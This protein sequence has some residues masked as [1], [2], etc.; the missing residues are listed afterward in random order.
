MK[1]FICAFGN[2]FLGIPAEQIQ[3]VIPVVRVQGSVFDTDDEE[4][5]ISIP[6]LFR[7]KGAAFNRET[8]HGL[9]LKDSLRINNWPGKIVLLVPK[10]DIDLEIPEEKIQRLPEVFAGAFVFFSGVC[11]P[12]DSGKM[13]LILD[14]EKLLANQKWKNKND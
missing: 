7:Q 2:N 13:I 10:I 9:V 1:Y 5:F 14:L 8:P 4:A 12:E 11:F 3:R 6:A